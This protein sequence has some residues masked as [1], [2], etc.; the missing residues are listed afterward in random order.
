M[1]RQANTAMKPQ[2][3]PSISCDLNFAKIYN[4][5]IAYISNAYN[6]YVAVFGSFERLDYTF[7]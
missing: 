1:P 4:S 3:M 5:V 7:E 6:S 2:P